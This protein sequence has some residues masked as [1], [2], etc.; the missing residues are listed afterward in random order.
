MKTGVGS[1]LKAV[2]VIRGLTFD[3]LSLIVT[4]GKQGWENAVD[5]WYALKSRCVF[6]S[7]PWEMFH[8]DPWGKSI[9]VFNN[10]FLLTLF[11]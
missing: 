9:V 1:K 6:S 4:D 5:M 2:L 11:C 8:C 3:T 7:Q 10:Q